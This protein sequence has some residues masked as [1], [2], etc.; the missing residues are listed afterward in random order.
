M[1][2]LVVDAGVAI[3]WF[4]HEIHSVE[5]RRILQQGHRLFAPDL[6]VVEFGSVLWKKVR[7][8]DLSREEAWN[9][10][11]MFK[12]VP[13]SLRSSNGLFA[14]ALDIAF[15]SGRSVYDSLYIACA[16]LLEIPMITAGERLYNATRNG[17]LTRHIVWVA[18]PPD[19]EA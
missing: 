2:R 8:G 1:S 3:K 17:P 6:L 10:H 5:A 16:V 19:Q 13:M 18:D 11:G 15:Q 12:T 4:V 14:S 7:R 9:I